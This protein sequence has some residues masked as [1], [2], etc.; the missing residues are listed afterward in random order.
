MKYSIVL[1]VFISSNCFCQDSYFPIIDENK[2]WIHQAKRMDQDGPCTLLSRYM[3]SFSGDTLV[4]NISYSKLYSHKITGYAPYRF[5][6]K[7]LYA[8]VREDTILRQVFSINIQN[9]NFC[10]DSENLV[11]DFSLTVGDTLNECA[12]NAIAYYSGDGVERGSINEISIESIF[13]K[14]R[15]VF[16]TFGVI[17]TCGLPFDIDYKII[18]GIGWERHGI[19]HDQSN[20]DDLIYYCEGSL[21]ECDI[22]SSLTEVKEVDLIVSPNPTSSNFTISTNE[23]IKKVA[24]YNM[25]SKGEELKSINGHEFNLSKLRPGLYII[26]IQLLNGGQVFSKVI[27]R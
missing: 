17:S 14:N 8:L 11:F 10:S 15:K 26:Q 2:Y 12:F 3:L 7:T 19:F 16:N 25:D 21:E 23:K 1:L 24:I 4:N 5:N 27:K 13:D 18:E 20:F 22:I 9:R 6:E